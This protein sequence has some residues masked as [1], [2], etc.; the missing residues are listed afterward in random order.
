MDISRT[1]SSLAI[2][3]GSLVELG[4]RQQPTKICQRPGVVRFVTIRPAAAGWGG[5]LSKLL[6]P[7]CLALWARR[8]FADL[9][10]L[11]RRVIVKFSAIR[12]IGGK[13]KLVL[14]GGQTGAVHRRRRQ[15]DMSRRFDSSGNGGK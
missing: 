12:G 8:V 11:R 14:R 9:P 4:W 1:I 10:S 6:D 5:Q 3:A 15:A 13:V 7:N 2:V